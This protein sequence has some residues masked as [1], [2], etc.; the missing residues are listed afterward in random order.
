MCEL[1]TLVYH[2]RNDFQLGLKFLSYPPELD[3][4]IQS[5]CVV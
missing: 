3:N 1:K 4:D 5:P 2:L